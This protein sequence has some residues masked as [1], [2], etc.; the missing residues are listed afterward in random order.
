M[1]CRNRPASRNGAENLSVEANHLWPPVARLYREQE[2]DKK[3]H[4]CIACPTMHSDSEDLVRVEGK[5]ITF[6]KASETFT[7]ASAPH[8]FLRNAV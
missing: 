6:L 4:P 7:K 3:E 2:K 1:G 8:Q 5:I